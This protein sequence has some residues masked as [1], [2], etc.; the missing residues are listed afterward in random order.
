MEAI[1]RS[2]IN[3]QEDGPDE[4]L[5]RKAAS[6]T[7]GKTGYRFGQ[8]I[9]KSPSQRQKIVKAAKLT[10]QNCNT[11]RHI[12]LD[13]YRAKAPAA[14]KVAE[15]Q[16]NYKV[17]LAKIPEEEIQAIP[18]KVIGGKPP[19]LLVSTPLPVRLK[20]QRSKTLVRIQ[21]RSHT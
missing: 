1:Y 8:L 10:C 18:G 5:K 16:T 4:S 14:S 9:A 13:C 3:E 6:N 19:R 2:F 12:S 7:I 15:T 21:P 11:V 20:P 17:L